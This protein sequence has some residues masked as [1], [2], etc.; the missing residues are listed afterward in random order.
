MSSRQ[1]YESLAPLLKKRLMPDHTKR[2]MF[3]SEQTRLQFV[4][5]LKQEALVVYRATPRVKNM[6]VSALRD[7]GSNVAYTGESIADVKAL[8]AANVSFSMGIVGCS[9]AREYADVVMTDDKVDSVLCAVKWGRNIIENVRKFIQYK[10]TITWSTALFII[11]ST[12]LLGHSPFTVLELLWINLMA[13][14]LA[15]LAFATEAPNPKNERKS[16]ISPK[17][18]ILT[19]TMVRTV[20]F[21]ALY[22]YLMMLLLLFF[23]PG[24]GDYRYN[25]F[26]TELKDDE[27]NPTQR[28]LHDSFMFH[29]FIIMNIFNM[30]NCRVLDTK[31]P[32]LG[33]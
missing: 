32:E 3:K 31:E 5:G 29:C 24:A 1:V 17:D 23:A 8:T 18:N 26:Q 22:Q 7:S 6:F 11:T 20:M 27:G 15:A 9:A 19:D 14:V 16:K 13:D 2:Y 25:L 4:D 12:L 30:V 21:Q 10:M 28:A 33:E